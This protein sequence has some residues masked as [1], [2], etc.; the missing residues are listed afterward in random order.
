[1][2]S[3]QSKKLLNALTKLKKTGPMLPPVN[4]DVPF[5]TFFMLHGIQRCVEEKRDG[6]GKP[7]VK[8]STLSAYAGMSMPAVSQILNSLEE[9]GL[10]ERKMDRNDRRVVYASLTPKGNQLLEDVMSCFSKFMDRIVDGLGNED[11]DRFVDLL[12]RF[13]IV[14][15]EI[16]QEDAA[17]CDTTP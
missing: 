5:G 9:K 11:T 6:E 16:R 3:E 12:N 8:I 13:Y 17:G 14:L 2:S 4:G 15:E 1:M 7:G 10:I